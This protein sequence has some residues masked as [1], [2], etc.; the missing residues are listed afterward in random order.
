MKDLAGVLDEC[1]PA[2]SEVA[3]EGPA[4]GDSSSLEEVETRAKPFDI[5]PTRVVLAAL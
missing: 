4:S 5:K 3:K 2:P 1:V